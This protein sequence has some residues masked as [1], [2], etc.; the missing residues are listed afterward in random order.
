MDG[1]VVRRTWGAT[2]QGGKRRVGTGPQIRGESVPLIHSNIHLKGFNELLIERTPLWA[3]ARH[4]A[5]ANNQ[6]TVRAR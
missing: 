1:Q 2:N 5:K 6:P 3:Q 4:Q